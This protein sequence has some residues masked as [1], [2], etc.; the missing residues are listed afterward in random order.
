ME[1][2][3]G[4]LASLFLGLAVFVFGIFLFRGSRR[5]FGILAGGGDFLDMNPDDKAFMREARRSG[6]AAWLLAVIIWCVGLWSVAPQAEAVR[7]TC[8]VVGVAS[9]AAVAVIIALQMR[10][11]IRLLEEN[12]G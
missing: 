3:Q 6:A 10:T 8:L 5:C 12:R 9:A 1:F 2:S 4:A 7:T 11:H